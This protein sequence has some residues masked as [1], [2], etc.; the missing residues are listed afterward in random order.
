MLS[1]LVSASPS[2]CAVVV[3]YNRA[4]LLAVCLGALRDQTHAIGRTVVIDNASTDHTQ[5]VL[6]AFPGVDVVR[7]PSN[8]GSSGGFAAGVEWAAE[9]ACDLVWVMDDDVEPEPDS[10]AHLVAAMQPGVAASGPVKVGTDGEVQPLHIAQYDLARMHKRAVVPARGE[11]IDVSF[12]SFVGLL[13]RGDVARAETP[14][15]DFFID[16]DDTEYCVRLA[17]HGRLVGVGASRIVHH[18]NQAQH[19]RRVMGRTVMTKGKWR[20][21]YAVRNPLL[22]SRAHATPRQW[23]VSVAVAAVQLALRL[24]AAL[25]HHGGDVQRWMLALRGFADGLRG[26]SGFIIAPSDY[27]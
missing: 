27:A 17:R 10:L 3:T 23:R 24:P 1:P 26:K 12:L 5:D 6:A 14:R 25:L 19:T 11:T 21:Y 4:D 2:V 18:N 13:I 20:V 16:A 7:L 8:A 15:A 9:T 22:I